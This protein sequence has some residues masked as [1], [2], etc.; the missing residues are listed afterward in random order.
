M[1]I[2]IR[3]PLVNGQKVEIQALF[4]RLLAIMQRRQMGGLVAEVTLAIRQNS[5][6]LKNAFYF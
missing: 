3:V 4:G 6:E 5:A 1:Q 2:C